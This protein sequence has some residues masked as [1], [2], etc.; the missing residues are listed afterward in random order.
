MMTNAAIHIQDLKKTYDGGYE[1]LKGV[2]FNVAEGEFFGLLG[3]NGA[4]KTTLISILSGL[5]RKTSGT[6]RIL[7][8]D[9]DTDRRSASMNLGVVPQEIVCDPFLTVRQTLEYQSGYYGLTDNKAWIEELVERLG[10]SDKIDAMTRG[11]SGGMRRRVLIAQALVHKPPVII[12]DEPTA[13]VD[14]EL[15]RQLWDF[16]GGLHRQ[17][18]TIILTTHYLE[19]AQALCSRVGVM[20]RGRL[21]AL[22]H[23]DRLLSRF[24]HNTMAFR[25]PNGVLPEALAPYVLHQ[26]GHQY[27]LRLT[28]TGDLETL[29][30]VLRTSGLTPENLTVKRASLEDAFVQLVGDK[31]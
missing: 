13:G 7:G 20:H 3:P 21:L 10:L 30:T 1:A 17:G 15:R 11:L 19:E 12:L 5:C 23:T 2:G 25:L 24:E 29:L 4:G 8:A 14:V 16:I 26:Q 27:T 6:V 31:A 28:E 9:I 18:H 22:D